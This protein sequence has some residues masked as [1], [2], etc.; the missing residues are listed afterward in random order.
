M[1]KYEVTTTIEYVGEV[2]ADSRE[3]AESMGWDWE[4]NLNYFAVDSIEVAELEDAEEDEDEE[5]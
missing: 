2:E 5:E 4:E 3:E 1:P